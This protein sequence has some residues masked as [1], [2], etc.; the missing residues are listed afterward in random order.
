MARK[1]IVRIFLAGFILIYAGALYGGG[2]KLL[3]G[4][5]WG[6][7]AADWDMGNVLKPGHLFGL[8]FEWGSG[9][10]NCEVDAL[11][12]LKTG[13]YPSRG[14]D[15]EMGEISVPF[16]AK[17]KFLSRSTPFVLAGCEAAYVLSHKQR[18]GPSGGDTVYD[19]I[20]NTR[21]IDYGL[22]VGAGFALEL[23]ALSLELS[24][25]YHHGL[26]KVSGLG[27][28]EYDLQTREWVVVLGLLFN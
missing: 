5:A 1:G 10:L 11:Y 9:R 21:R 22:V 4:L 19:M 3:G 24:G 8:G 14:W 25:R 13:A 20:D 15:Y 23:G 18:P 12:F 16:M 17:Y 26:A 28:R 6:K 7:Y 27:Y 2:P